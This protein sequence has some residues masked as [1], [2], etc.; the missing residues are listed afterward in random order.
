MA[1][2]LDSLQGTSR[3]PFPQQTL[4][5]TAVGRGLDPNAEVTTEILSSRSYRLAEADLLMWLSVSPNV[6]Q[7]EQHY[8]W[9]TEQRQY[10]RDRAMF[11]Y[12]AEKDTENPTDK[13]DYGY[14]GCR[15]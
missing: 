4:I 5:D 11:I 14:K 15:L 13:V 2:I 1:T 9:N 12:N 7:G 8:A 10:L 6:V 3:Y